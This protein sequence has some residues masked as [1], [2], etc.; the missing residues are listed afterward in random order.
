MELL[1]PFVL[2]IG[3][4]LLMT[5]SAKNKQRQAMQ[6]RDAMEPGTGVR[7]IGGMYALV[8]EVREDTVQLEITPGVHVLF[9]KNAIAAVLDAEEYERIVSGEEHGDEETPE[10]PDD[11]SALTEGEERPDGGRVE[12]DK[13]ENGEDGKPKSSDDEGDNGPKS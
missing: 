9:A 10:V 8:K 7:T 1:F 4:M 5:R 6:M 12:L 2:I 3:L 11:A 13:S